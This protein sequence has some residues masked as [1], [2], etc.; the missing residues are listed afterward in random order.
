MLGD[1][2]RDGKTKVGIYD[3]STGTW[4]LWNNQTN[5]ADAIIFGWSNTVPIVGDW[6]H[7]GKT[8]IGVYDPATKNFYPRNPE[9][10]YFIPVELCCVRSI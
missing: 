1:W 7:D 4:A 5:S 3:S 8:D 6:I 2:N 9:R 10:V